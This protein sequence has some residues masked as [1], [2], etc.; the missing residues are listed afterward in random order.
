M[1]AKA[2]Q[3]QQSTDRALI[4]EPGTAVQEHSAGKIPT[5]KCIKFQRKKKKK[6]ENW[7]GATLK[8]ISREE[9]RL[10]VPHMTNDHLAS[11]DF[12]G[13]LPL[14]MSISVQ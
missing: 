2:T 9:E 14:P 10:A 4:A 12:L 5:K 8:V 3:E 6:A 11:S 7:K 1:E 13:V